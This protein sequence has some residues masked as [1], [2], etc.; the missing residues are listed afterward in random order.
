MGCLDQ[1]EVS[2]K[3]LHLLCHIIMWAVVLTKGRCY[4]VFLWFLTAFKEVFF[5]AQHP[6]PATSK[7]FFFSSSKP[8]INIR[9]MYLE[10]ST[11]LGACEWHGTETTTSCDFL[12][13]SH[14][15]TPQLRLHISILYRHMLTEGIVRRK[16]VLPI[17]ILIHSN[18]IKNK[19]MIPSIFL[20]LK[21]KL[22]NLQT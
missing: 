5:T 9:A 11:S 3:L 21:R 22:S 10:Y 13:S 2:V 17:T 7:G 14:L 1:S 6:K 4:M 20:S 19:C 12:T 16:R 15:S 18:A 8:L